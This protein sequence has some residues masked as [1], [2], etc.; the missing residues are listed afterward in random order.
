MNGGGPRP[1]RV[2]NVAE[3]PSVAKEVARILS[4]GHNVPHSEQVGRCARPPPFLARPAHR[5]RSAQYNRVYSFG[6]TI[7]NTPCDMR[8]TSITGARFSARLVAFASVSRGPPGHLLETDFHADFKHWRD[9]E[10][11]LLLTTA[12]VVTVVPD[13]NRDLAAMLRAEAAGAKWLILW[14][15]CDR[16][17]EAIAKEVR[18]NDDSRA[19]L[20]SSPNARVCAGD[21]CVPGRQPRPAGEARAVL[22]ADPR[23]RVARRRPAAGR[24]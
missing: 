15:D 5:R 3:K 22:G 14:L 17:G 12:Q 4:G 20:P 13:K 19:P 18:C 24:P 2:L 6:C 21:G 23:G 11:R 1:V 7:Q 8:F 9:T 16:E 10:Q